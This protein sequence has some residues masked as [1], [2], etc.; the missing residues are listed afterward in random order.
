[1]CSM[2]APTKTEYFK[3]RSETGNTTQIK[4]GIESFNNWLTRDPWLRHSDLFRQIVRETLTANEQKITK[5]QEPYLMKSGWSK[6]LER[7]KSAGQ[8]RKKKVFHLRF[9]GEAKVDVEAGQSRVKELG[10]SHAWC[11]L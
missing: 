5:L 1:M 3:L 6:L 9:V 2:K 8:M 10:R 11:E 7:E 4:S